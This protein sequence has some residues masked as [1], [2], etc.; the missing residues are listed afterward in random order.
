EKKEEK[1]EELTKTWLGITV[2]EAS[3]IK[4]VEV[5]EVEAGSVGDLAGI[6]S[7]DI[8]L[9]ID[10]YEITSIADFSRAVNALKNTKRPILFRIKRG[11]ASLF[12]AVTPE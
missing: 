6:Q 9:K 4:G 11:S 8:I 12:I 7:G 5:S 1:S 10:K 2:K 3:G